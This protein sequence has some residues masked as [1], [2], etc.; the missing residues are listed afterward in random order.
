MIE[1]FIKMNG[2]D[3]L[4]V[5]R[6]NMKYTGTVIIPYVFLFNSYIEKYTN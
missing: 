5:N 2:F 3:L 6:S 4:Y 1:M